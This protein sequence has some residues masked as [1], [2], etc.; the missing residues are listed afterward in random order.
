MIGPYPIPL[1]ALVEALDDLSQLRLQLQ[2][3]FELSAA[4]DLLVQLRSIKGGQGCEATVDGNIVGRHQ[5]RTVT[6]VQRCRQELFGGRGVLPCHEVCQAA[7]TS[8]PRDQA[9]V[10]IV[11]G[12]SLGLPQLR[13]GQGCDWSMV[14]RCVRW[15]HYFS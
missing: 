10:I 9:L 1:P 5:V 6:V 13:C 11:G 12:G 4:D 3:Q 14:G 8:Q 15:R 7:S 2:E